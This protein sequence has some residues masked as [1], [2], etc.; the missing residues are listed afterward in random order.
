MIQNQPRNR[1]ENIHTLNLLG[2]LTEMPLDCIEALTMIVEGDTKGRAVTGWA[3]KSK[4]IIRAAMKSTSTEARAM[5]GDLVNL[6][7]SR[8]YFDFGAL[9]K[10]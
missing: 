4:E 1:K 8:G 7:G 9:L 10:E 6:L 3:D 5:A 2:T